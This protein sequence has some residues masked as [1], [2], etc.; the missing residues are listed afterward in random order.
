VALI[1]L[2]KNRIE[3]QPDGNSNRRSPTLKSRTM[4]PPEPEKSSGSKAVAVRKSETR[5]EQVIPLTGEDFR[6]F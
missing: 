2:E 3:T 4:I 6:D 1:L 5:P